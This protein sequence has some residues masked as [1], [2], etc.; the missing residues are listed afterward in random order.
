M[1][2]Q[3][4]KATWEILVTIIKF[5]FNKSGVSK[6]SIS[7]SVMGIVEKEW[8]QINTD[9]KSKSPAVL[10]NALIKADKSL[11]NL[12]KE[13]VHG[14][15]MG[16]RMIAGKNRFSSDVYS[17]IWSAH[18]VRNAMVH[19]SGYEP[20]YYILEEAIENLRRGV[21]QLGARV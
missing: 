20:T 3:I 15:T 21:K 2:G 13:L 6:K 18:K 14:N 8:K 7:S 16:E 4:L 19:E 11:D 9:L 17:R 1:L 10:K 5:F 12:L